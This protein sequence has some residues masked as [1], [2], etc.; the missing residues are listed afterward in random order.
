MP[1]AEA[2]GVGWRV[3]RLEEGS[4]KGGK[5]TRDPGII[6]ERRL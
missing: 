5:I 6:R 2:G 3:V 1:C 4:R